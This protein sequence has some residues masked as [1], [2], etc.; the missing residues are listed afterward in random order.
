MVTCVSEELVAFIF[1]VHTHKR[2][3]KVIS[4]VC[5]HSRPV[6]PRDFTQSGFPTRYLNVLFDF[7]VVPEA[8]PLYLMVFNHTLL[9]RNR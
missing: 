3:V 6:V 7:S 4:I 9:L 2:Y 8:I 1:R 5:Y